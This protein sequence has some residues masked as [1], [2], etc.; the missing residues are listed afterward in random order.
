MKWKK[1]NKAFWYF[2]IISPVLAKIIEWIFQYIGYTNSQDYFMF[3]K[4][5]WLLQIIFIDLLA[6]GVYYLIKFKKQPSLYQMTF[7]VGIAYFFKEVY[8]QIFVFSSFNVYHL[9]A[10]IIEPVFMWAVLGYLPYKLFFK[11]EG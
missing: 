7:I 10:L 8:N 4:S 5:A 2:T 6:L 3:L 1:F 11:G 9:I